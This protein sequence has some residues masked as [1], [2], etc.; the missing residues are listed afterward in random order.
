ME[1]L[2]Y[3]KNSS[4]FLYENTYFMLCES[5]FWCCTFYGSLKKTANLT[6]PYCCY[7]RLKLISILLNEI[8]YGFGDSLKKCGVMTLGTKENNNFKRTRSSVSYSV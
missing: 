7:D 1:T 8:D 4:Q 3:H 2:L 6:C 5:C